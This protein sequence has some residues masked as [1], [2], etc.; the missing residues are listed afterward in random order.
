[1]CDCTLHVAWGE[2]G[3]WYRKYSATSLA[4]ISILCQCFDTDGWVQER[5]LP[6]NNPK[7]LIPGGSLEQVEEED[8]TKNWLTEIHL[9]K[10]LL[11]ETSSSSS[12]SSS[13]FCLTA[14]R[15]SHA[16]RD[17]TVLPVTRQRWE[18]CVYP[19]PKQVLDLATRRDARLRS[20]DLSDASPTP[21]CSA[22]MQYSSS[23][24][25]SSSSSRLKCLFYRCFCWIQWMSAELSVWLTCACECRQEKLEQLAA[26]FDRKAGMREVWLSENQRLVAQDNFG[27]DLA[28][29]EAAVKKHEAIETD[30]N[31]YEERVQAV[32]SVAQELETE[33]YHLSLIHIWR[34]RR[35]T[36]CR[37]RWSPYH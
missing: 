33:K 30:I 12:S 3:D 22:T 16:I 29:V 20:R 1:M 4:G 23:S 18:S 7:L 21:Y 14:T 8:P 2:S 9:E 28:A 37:S 35:S 32:V 24:N 31:A 5:Q 34:C 19:Q 13:S 10:W 27:F 11:N 25:S 15:N 36:L 26:R 6:H 17:H